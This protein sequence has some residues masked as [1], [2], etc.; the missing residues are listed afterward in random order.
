MVRC[1]KSERG[2]VAQPGIPGLRQSG[3]SRA[4]RE[5]RVDATSPKS[6]GGFTVLWDRATEANTLLRAMA[7][8]NRLM[9]LCLLAGG[10]RSVGEIEAMTGAR[11]PTV[12]QQL[13]RLRADGLVESRRD[14]KTIY[15]SLLC[16]RIR[17]ILALLDELCSE[18][19][20]E[21]QAGAAD[22]ARGRG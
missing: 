8:E 17:R 6:K 15:Y 1:A 2:V 18:E 20:D 16:G 21:R 5:G 4:R 7:N 13:A 9:I 11:Q 14:G 3:F 22:E 10:E 12:S 19:H